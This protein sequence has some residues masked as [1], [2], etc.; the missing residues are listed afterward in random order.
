MEDALAHAEVYMWL[1]K[2]ENV[3]IRRRSVVAILDTEAAGDQNLK[4]QKLNPP[5]S[6]R[7][8]NEGREGKRFRSFD[9]EELLPLNTTPTQIR[10][11]TRDSGLYAKPFPLK[12]P[13]VE[14]RNKFAFCD[15]HQDYD[16]ITDTCFFLEEADR[17]TDQKRYVSQVCNLYKRASARKEE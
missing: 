9:E 7:Y 12:K 6:F 4:P 17:Y 5:T 11:E 10:K 2:D 1:E 8:A 14:R 15:F 16:H 13:F 3:Q